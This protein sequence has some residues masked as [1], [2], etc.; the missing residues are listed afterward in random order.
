MAATLPVT[1]LGTQRMSKESA[2]HGGPPPMA[3]R[4]PWADGLFSVLAHG[5]AWLTLA[6]PWE[7]TDHGAACTNS[8]ELV[9]RMAYCTLPML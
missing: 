8:P 6:L 1:P 7:A 9:T 2:P 3:Q 4:T 5:A